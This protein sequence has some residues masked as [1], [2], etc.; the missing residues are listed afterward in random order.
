MIRTLLLILV[1][2]TFLV[3]CGGKTDEPSSS[4]SSGSTSSGSTSSGS[5]SSSGSGYQNIP[6]DALLGETQYQEKCQVCHGGGGE[7][8]TQLKSPPLVG[9]S[10]CDNPSSLS[11]YIDKTMPPGGSSA[12]K[13]CAADCAVNVSAYIIKEF[14]RQPDTSACATGSESPSP[15]VFKRLSRQEYSNTIME[16]LQLPQAPNVEAIPNDPSVHNFQ[17]IA[18]IQ[19]VQPSHLNG[20][21]SIATEQAEAL[22]N[23]PSRRDKVIGCTYTN[24]S[25]IDNF[26][27]DFGRLAYRRPLSNGELTRINQYVDDNSESTQDQFV[28]AIQLLLSSPNFIYR[29]EVG[30]N[31]EGLATL[32]QY[33]LVSRL[34]FAL[35]GRGPTTELLDQAENGALES[36][37][38]L[39]QIAKE[40]LNDPKA[41]Q[42]MSLFFEQWLATNLLHTPIEKPQNWYSTIFEDM[43]AETNKLLGEYAWEGKDF[44]RV[45]TENRTYLTPSLADYY[46]LER[47]DSSNQAVN[48]PSGDPRQG[49]GILTHA[50]SMFP[51][52]DGDLV[53]IRGNWLRS[54]FLCKKL[55]LPDGITEIING[56]FSGFTPIEIIAARNSDSSCDRCH[57]QIDPIGIAFAPFS[58]EGLFDH[59]VNLSDYPIEP[60]FPDSGDSNIKTIQDI[61]QALSE[62][63]EVGQCIADRLFLYTRNHE[64]E[65]SDHCSVHNANQSFQSSGRQFASLLLSL[66]E[67]PSFRTRLAPEPT[68][69]KE[70]EPEVRNVALDKSV[71]TSSAQDGN[72]GSRITD[73]NVNSDSRWS[74]QG[75]PQQA[76]IDLGSV[77]TVVQSEVYP[78]EDRAYQYTIEVSTNGSNYTPIVD[79]SN[80]E[81]GGN[82]ISDLFAP[83]DARYIRLKVTGVSGGYTGD[84]IS[85]REV[86]IFGTQK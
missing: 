86:K 17:T 70:A 14:N 78:F 11:Q 4:S 50:A 42:N 65:P 37:S 25:C 83:V 3:A 81:Q 19:G 9:C 43:K 62:M 20:Y 71:T 82:A 21:I 47:P 52:T 1:C 67:D 84:W 29:V 85:F 66:V 39:Q 41:K 15:S 46:G 16:L 10:I 44:M 51:K 30:N 34:S 80:N 8:S 64:P 40:M 57:A 61:A 33:E 6:G 26:I 36:E 54:T 63:P 12:V 77:Y 28:L 53:A 55:E 38:G 76:T 22:M 23:T 27:Q 5:G 18:S 60:G 79:R 72:P 68:E 32:D 56:K 49:T 69:E 7:G 59:T 73:N 48:L 2:S 35:W 75:F 13:N 58:R 74:V 31:P 24:Q 45:F